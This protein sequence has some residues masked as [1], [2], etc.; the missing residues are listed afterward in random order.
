MLRYR[1]GRRP[2]TRP[3]A[4]STENGRGVSRTGF[5]CALCVTPGPGGA[6]PACRPLVRSDFG[7]YA[8]SVRG[9]L[10]GRHGRP[11]VPVPVLVC[12]TPSREVHLQSMGLTTLG[13]GCGAASRTPTQARSAGLT[14]EGGTVHISA[15]LTPVQRQ[16]AHALQPRRRALAAPGCNPGQR[17]VAPL[18]R[19]TPV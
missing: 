19:G 7:Y 5:R 15:P 16:K 18:Q 3:S 11:F 12:V 6:P 1:Y 14:P 10:S 17:T 9:T 13:Q 4:L 8:G 2:V